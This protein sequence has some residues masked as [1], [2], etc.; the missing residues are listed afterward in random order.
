MV[1][2]NYGTVGDIFK[3]KGGRKWNVRGYKSFL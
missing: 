2:E 1:A 3:A